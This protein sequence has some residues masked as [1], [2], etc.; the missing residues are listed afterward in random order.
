MTGALV[1]T[2][3]V[4]ARLGALVVLVIRTFVDIYG[5]VAIRSTLP[6]G[7]TGINYPFHKKVPCNLIDTD[8]LRV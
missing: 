4:D 3:G 6:S 7:F 5:T 2:W 8:R 1:A